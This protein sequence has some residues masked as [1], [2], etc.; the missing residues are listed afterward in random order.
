MAPPLPPPADRPMVVTAWFAEE[1]L[2]PF[3]ALRRRFFPPERNYLDAHLTLFHHIPPGIRGAFLHAAADACAG[4]PP[5]PVEIRPPFLLGRGVAYAVASDG[6]R[7]LR[8]RLVEQFS[9]SLTAQDL[10]SWGRPHLT[11]Q[12]KV[13]PED[14]HRLLRRLQPRFTPCHIALKGLSCHTYDGGPWSLI[15]HLPFGKP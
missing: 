6:L 10:N 14:A 13:A 11:V 3:N 9:P 5:V 2:A 12:N 8:S 15:T 7:H 1:D 4:L